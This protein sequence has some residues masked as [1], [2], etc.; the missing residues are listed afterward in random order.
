MSKRER[1]H[2]QRWGFDAIGRRVEILW[3]EGEWFSGVVQDFD[4]SCD[5][6]HV[7][8]DD[9]D[10]KW[11]DLTDEAYH[12]QLRW[13]GGL[14]P[15]Q[16]KISGKRRASRPATVQASLPEPAASVASQ[17]DCSSAASSAAI[18]PPAQTEPAPWEEEGHPWIGRRVRRTCGW[19]LHGKE[20]RL[21]EV[22]DGTIT[23]WLPAGDG[24]YEPALWHMCHDDG[25]EEDLEECEASE[26][27]LAMERGVYE[28]TY[29]DLIRE[30]V[31]A[32]V[33]YVE[34]GG[35]VQPVYE[36]LPTKE[37]A[38]SY[39]GSR[40]VYIG[41]MYGHVDSKMYLAT[42]H[43]RHMTTSCR[44]PFLA[45][46]PKQENPRPFIR[47]QGWT[48][49]THVK[50][51]GWPTRHPAA[52]SI[53][54]KGAVSGG[55][56]R[57]QAIMFAA[58]RWPKWYEFIPPQ[59]SDWN[60]DK[61]V[62]QNDGVVTHILGESV[63]PAMATSIME[64]AAA[65]LVKEGCTPITE[66]VDLFCCGGGFSLG[67]AA[68][69]PSVQHV[70]GVD[71]DG[72][73]LRNYAHNIAKAWPGAKVQV[74][75]RKAPTSCAALCK[76]LKRRSLGEG[77]HIHASPPCQAFVNTCSETPT[78]LSMYFQM[79]V[80]ARKAGCTVSFEEHAH[81][82]KQAVS[83]LKRQSVEDQKVL[84]VYKVTA[85]DYGS[86]TGR[87]RCVVTSFPLIGETRL[88]AQEEG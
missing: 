72:M 79:L 29:S 28:K 16:V 27:L 59:R 37:T 26:A 44:D 6:H 38:E 31:E 21:I 35:R 68:A 56:V 14:V 24:P 11:H 55:M 22:A 63:M 4:A 8:Y 62:K 15:S 20:E 3:N 18:E 19:K 84:Y 71:V 67:A 34:E 5:E 45:V 23:K 9:H 39:F 33:N 1:G 49:C 46:V 50:D 2:A 70:H 41:N 32:G 88:N 87:E 13:I 51:D 82:H 66:L 75:E 30:Y 36:A 58:V 12:G 25:D 54:A 83:W 17:L 64:Q 53:V 48:N 74:H 40:D 78:D 47:C 76:M 69:L 77:I 60:W 43:G 7:L 61:V 57:S 85:R 86:P 81:A 80:D 65:S 10:Q 42:N 73:V 52:A